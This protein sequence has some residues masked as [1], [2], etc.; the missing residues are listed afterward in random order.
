LEEEEP[1]SSVAVPSVEEAAAAGEG[2]VAGVAEGGDGNPVVSSVQVS[3]VEHPEPSCPYP[4]RKD[5][6]YPWRT[7]PHDPSA[8]SEGEG[9]LVVD[10][11]EPGDSLHPGRT[12]AG[13]HWRPWFD[14]SGC[15]T[16]P[17]IYTG[18]RSPGIAAS[19]HDLVD[20]D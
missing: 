20:N 3:A 13:V 4:D 11:S 14:R 5:W 7:D 8:L 1:V 16:C 9:V 2:V 18:I 19:V 17:A 10:L 12:G 15:R 6:T